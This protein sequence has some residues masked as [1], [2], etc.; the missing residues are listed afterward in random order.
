VVATNIG[1]TPEMVRDGVTGFIVPPASAPQLA[2]RLLL[3]L[4]DRALSERMGAAGRNVALAE[5]AT[6]RMIDRFE[7]TYAEILQPAEPG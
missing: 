3:L 5:L 4:G 1:G 2:D 6:G 7:S